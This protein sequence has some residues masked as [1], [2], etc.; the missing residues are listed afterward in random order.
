V[1]TYRQRYRHSLGGIRWGYFCGGIV[2]GIKNMGKGSPW[3][4]WPKLLA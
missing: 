4:T 3:S 1:A 2:K